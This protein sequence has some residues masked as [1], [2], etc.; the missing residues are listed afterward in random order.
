M[1]LSSCEVHEG[2]GSRFGLF[3]WGGNVHCVQAEGTTGFVD[4]MPSKTCGSIYYQ[5]ITQVVIGMALTDRVSLQES[6]QFPAVMHEKI[7]TSWMSK[8]N[9]TN[10]PQNQI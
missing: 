2:R 8:G 3:K 4:G 9:Q 5:R 7:N 10:P 6:A 1:E